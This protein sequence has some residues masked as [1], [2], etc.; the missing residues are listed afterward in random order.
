MAYGV[1]GF[2]AHTISYEFNM[3]FCGGWGWAIWVH[4]SLSQYCICPC[5]HQHSVGLGTCPGPVQSS[6]SA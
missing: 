4:I 6:E 3:A 5:C 2:L 1:G